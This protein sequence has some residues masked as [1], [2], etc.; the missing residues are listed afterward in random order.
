MNLG[1]VPQHES[2]STV[3]VSIERKR[4]LF[5]VTAKDS[6]GITHSSFSRPSQTIFSPF[7]IFSPFAM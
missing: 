2:D 4:R 7:S 1:P 6:N 5:H 3:G